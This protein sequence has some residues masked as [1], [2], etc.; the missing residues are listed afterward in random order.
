MARG[1]NTPLRKEPTFD[2]AES[3]K[4]LPPGLNNPAPHSSQTAMQIDVP[5]ALQSIDVGKS[6]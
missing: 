6:R 2:R 3:G 4:K 5:V 1:V